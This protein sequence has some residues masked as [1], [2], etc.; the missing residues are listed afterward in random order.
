MNSNV[1]VSTIANMCVDENCDRGVWFL[2]SETRYLYHTPVHI[3]D[4]IVFNQDHVGIITNMII[5]K[6][7][8]YDNK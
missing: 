8:Q 3:V 4:L 2:I 6:N 7:Y 1:R 5:L